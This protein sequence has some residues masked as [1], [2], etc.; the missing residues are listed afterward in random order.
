[1]DAIC[2]LKFAKGHNSVKN[3]GGVMVLVLSTLPDHALYLY[4][5]MSQYLV[6]FQSYGP[7]Q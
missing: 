4:K 6:E 1:M 5:V 2:K 3:V 7:E